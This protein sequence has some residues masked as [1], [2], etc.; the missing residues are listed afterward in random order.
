MLQTQLVRRLERPVT[1]KELRAEG[2]KTGSPIADL[3]LLKM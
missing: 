3:T 2:E 1:L